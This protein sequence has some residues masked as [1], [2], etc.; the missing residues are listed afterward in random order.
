MIAIRF[1]VI[2]SYSF[3]YPHSD[4]KCFLVFSGACPAV[5]EATRTNTCYSQKILLTW[6]ERSAKTNVPHRSTQQLS[7]RPILTPNRR[8]TPDLHRRPIYIV[9]HRSILHRVHR[10]I[11][12]RETWLRLL[13]S[14]RTRMETCMTKMVISVMQHVRN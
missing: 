8:P 4:T 3:L 12:S 2:N 7:R 11:I 6:N 13:F 14:D 1:S 10:S 9:R 5:P